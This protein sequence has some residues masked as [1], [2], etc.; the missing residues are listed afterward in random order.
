MIIKIYPKPLEG[1]KKFLNLNR[2]LFYY[3]LNKMNPVLP[4]EGRGGFIQI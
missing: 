1:L 4:S 3:N 2:L